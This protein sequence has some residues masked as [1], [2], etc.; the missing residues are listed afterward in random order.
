MES[1]QPGKM[2]RGRGVRRC[3]RVTAGRTV[4]T[5]R[6][7]DDG[8]RVTVRAVE[9]ERGRIART[10]RCG[11]RARAAGGGRSNRKQEYSGRVHGKLTAG[12]RRA[13]QDP[14]RARNPGER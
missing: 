3:E 10:V 8:G 7:A 2:R 6:G 5:C 14:A 13:G 12:D 9:V 1:V 11:T 4:A